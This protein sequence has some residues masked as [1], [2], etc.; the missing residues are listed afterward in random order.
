LIVQE[1]GEEFPDDNV[2]GGDVESE[3]D[4]PIGYVKKIGLWDV[5]YATVIRISFFNEDNESK[6]AQ[7]AVPIL[8]DNSCQLLSLATDKVAGPVTKLS[9]VMARSAGI[10]SV[11]I[12]YTPPSTPAPPTSDGRHPSA[13]N[14]DAPNAM[15]PTDHPVLAQANLQP[16]RQVLA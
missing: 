14:R 15:T 12:F 5:D 1:P 11:S 6:D 3:F 9:I 2:D 4:L 13:T 7:I 16:R 8:G 10:A